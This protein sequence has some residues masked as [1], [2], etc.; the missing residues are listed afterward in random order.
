M[1]KEI[2]KN[3]Y[4]KSVFKYLDWVVSKHKSKIV[5]RGNFSKE[6]RTEEDMDKHPDEA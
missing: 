3:S 4:G 1:K 5:F 6:V 2:N